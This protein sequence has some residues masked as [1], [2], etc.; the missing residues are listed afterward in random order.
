MLPFPIDRYAE[1]SVALG[2]V[3]G[4]TPWRERFDAVLEKAASF[5]LA[6]DELPLDR[7]LDGH[8]F[9]AFRFMAGLAMMRAEVLQAE[10]RLIAVTD[11]AAAANIAGTSRAV[12]DWLDAGRPLDTIAF[13][14][15]RKAPAG[16]ARGASAFRPVVLLWDV[17]GGRADEKA[18]GK[19][20]VVQKEGF[21]RR[22]A[23]LARR[24]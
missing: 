17:A 23:L 4:A 16:R 10:C 18:V 19:S 20:G 3:E 12:A 6:D 13:P 7:D 1:L 11:G 24:G 8:F 22:G 5:T 9:Y 2:D 21:F 15:A 14:F